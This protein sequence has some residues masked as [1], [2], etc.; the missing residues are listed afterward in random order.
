MHLCSLKESHTHPQIKT[1][2]S[3]V[4]AVPEPATLALLGLGLAGI[5][6]SRRRKLTADPRTD[7]TRPRPMAG[8]SF[9]MRAARVAI[10]ATD[11][12]AA[13]YDWPVVADSRRCLSI[14]GLKALW[15]FR[16]AVA[17]CGRRDN[18]RPSPFNRC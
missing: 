13:Q 14:L 15:I 1:F 12:F 16:C 17:Q 18:R 8:F 3:Q 9:C 2:L 5:A 7:A 6:A 10:T 11:R 4:A